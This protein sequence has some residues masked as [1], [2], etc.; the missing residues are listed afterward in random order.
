MTDLE[1]GWFVGIMDGE[2]C[3]TMIKT[4]YSKPSWRHPKITISSTDLE[5]L[6]RC[7]IITNFGYIVKKKESRIGAKPAWIWTVGGGTQVLY[8]LKLIQSHLICPNK[9][10][11]A[12][13][14]IENY[15]RFCKRN[16]YYTEEEKLSKLE[17]EKIFF[18]L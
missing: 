4:N 11:R 2:G 15:P 17:F 1:L 12:R 9:K 10:L 7:K 13:Y 6:N 16:G 5:I 8:L 18:E 3:V 14:L